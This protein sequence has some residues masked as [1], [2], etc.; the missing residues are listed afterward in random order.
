MRKKL[1]GYDLDGTLIDTRKDLIMGVRYMLKEMGK[2]ILT[3]KAIEYCV[4][5]GL[6]QLVAM[7]LGETEPKIVEKA[8]RIL[9]KY[10]KAHLLDYTKLYPQ[11][12]TVLDRFSDR[13]QVVITNKPERARKVLGYP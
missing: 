6:L 9:R 11:A 7:T 1:I 13:I 12:Q 10:Y 2:P 8:A 4:G 3:D 5:E